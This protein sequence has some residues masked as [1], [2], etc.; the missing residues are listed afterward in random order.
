MIEW[1]QNDVKTLS[2]DPPSSFHTKKPK[3]EEQPDSESEDEEHD[4]LLDLPAKINENKKGRSSVSAE[5]YG[6]YNQKTTYMPKFIKK[7]HDQ[8]ERISK[9]LGQAFMFQALD[10]KE[11][12]IVINAMEERIFSY[13]FFFSFFENL[14]IKIYFLIF[15]FCIYSVCPFKFRICTKIIFMS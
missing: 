14:F 7:T 11:K 13:L 12:E 15:H 8:K 1:L 6:L 5:V 4:E 10:E 3:N 2:S 9:R